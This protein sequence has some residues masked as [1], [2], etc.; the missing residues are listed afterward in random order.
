MLP[1]GR[2]LPARDA[3]ALHPGCGLEGCGQRRLPPKQ[4]QES[5]SLEGY[6]AEAGGEV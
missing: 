5:L 3:D 6:E 2:Q 1:Q 4:G